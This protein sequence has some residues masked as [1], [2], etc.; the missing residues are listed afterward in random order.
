LIDDWG[1]D[2][3][4]YGLATRSPDD[5]WRVEGSLK[6]ET[7]GLADFA[8]IDASAAFGAGTLSGYPIAYVGIM[9]DLYFMG[10]DVGATVLVGSFD[11]TSPILRAAGYA[12][13]LDML[14]SQN[15]YTGWYVR[16]YAEM[17]LIDSY[18]CLMKANAGLGV[19][20]WY[21]MN[22]AGIGTYGGDLSGYVYAQVAC[23]LSARGNLT[24]GYARLDQGGTQYSRTC[25]APQCDVYGGNFWVATGV[26]WCEPKTWHTWSS[27]WW[28]DSWCYTFGAYVDLSY[29]TPPGGWDG[30]DFNIDLDFE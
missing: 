18:G 17:P 1:T 6:L 24:L 29:L 22:Q 2:G 4:F 27:R 21:L 30:W 9:A 14:G 16:A 23:I 11:K 10:Y 15:L 20:V 3:Y 12:D 19:R 26:G 25:N 7:I 13:A 5:E 28:G 8:G